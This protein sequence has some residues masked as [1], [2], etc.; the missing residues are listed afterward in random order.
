M[1][2]A[3]PVMFTSIKGIIKTHILFA[4]FNGAI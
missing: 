1:V 4:G 2:R 3:A